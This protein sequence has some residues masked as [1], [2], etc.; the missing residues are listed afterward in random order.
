MEFSSSFILL[1]L[2]SKSQFVQQKLFCFFQN[3]IK[4]HPVVY[5]CRRVEVEKSAR[6]TGGHRQCPCVH[7]QTEKP[8]Q[9]QPEK[10]PSVM[11]FS[12]AITPE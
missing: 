7:Q 10:Q 8:R 1:F 5:S 2:I 11:V 4:T 3:S 12:G 6:V 9:A